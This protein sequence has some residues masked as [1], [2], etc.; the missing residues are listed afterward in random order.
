MTPHLLPLPP[1]LSVTEMKEF[2]PVRNVAKCLK[3]I[4]LAPA[5][6]QVR[7]IVTRSITQNVAWSSIANVQHALR[8]FAARPTR[9]PTFLLAHV[10]HLAL[11]LGLR[12]SSKRGRPLNNSRR[13]PRTPRT[14]Q[15]TRR[16]EVE[17]EERAEECKRAAARKTMVQV[18][19]LSPLA[20]NDIRRHPSSPTL[21][22][23]PQRTQLEASLRAL[24]LEST[25]LWPQFPCLCLRLHLT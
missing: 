17:A 20:A 14:H 4:V 25:H 19:L 9:N 11:K 16:R 5:I 22:H 21:A 10:Q 3:Q 8:S 15:P 2:Y 24:L 7:T 13:G 12:S 23:A 6:A 1:M 18:Q